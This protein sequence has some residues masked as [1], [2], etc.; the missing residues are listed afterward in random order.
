MKW[1]KHIS[2][3]LDDPFIFDLIDQFGGDGY[4]VFFGTLEVMAREFDMFSPG[5]CS[6]SVRFLTKKL[7]LSAKKTLKI[8]NFCDKNNRILIARAGDRITLNCPKLKDLC[9]EFTKKKL[10]RLSGVTP[11]LLR[12][13]SGTDLDLDLDLDK[14]KS[15][16]PLP[17]QGGRARKTKY[18]IPYPD[19]FLAWY[20][21]YP[22]KKSKRDA[23]KAWNDTRKA[24]PSLGDMLRKLELQIKS[25]EWQKESGK[26]I[27][28]PGTYLRAGGWDD[29]TIINMEIDYGEPP[30]EK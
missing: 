9:D 22:K 4:L 13:Y 19:K 7:Q 20:E 17:P 12:S 27:P 30:E 3:S 11:E 15:T 25:H 14:E 2:D 29:E 23:F 18:E 28:Y 26:Y 24:R 6:I 21:V 5:T 16:P 10:G 8:L 1:F